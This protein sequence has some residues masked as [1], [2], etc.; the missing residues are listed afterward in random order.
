MSYEVQEA[1]LTFLDLF[2]CKGVAHYTRGNIL[3]ISE[4]LIGVFNWFD[5]VH[6]FQEDHVTDSLT[7]LSICSNSCF[8]SIFEHLKQSADLDNLEEIHTTGPNAA[9]VEKIEAILEK[10]VDVHDKLCPAQVCTK[11]MHGGRNMLNSIAHKENSC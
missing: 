4:K 2:K 3:Q 7:R 1:M 8:Q 9:T 5:E 11:L 6:D 10:A